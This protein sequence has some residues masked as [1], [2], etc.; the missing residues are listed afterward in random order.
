VLGGMLGASDGAPLGL[1]LGDPEG[2]RVGDNE[3]CIEGE[4]DLIADGV[5]LG[6]LLD[7]HV[8]GDDTGKSAGLFRGPVVGLVNCSGVGGIVGVLDGSRVGELLGG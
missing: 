7:G 1:R 6:T 3:G 2:A 5:T 4:D 8:V